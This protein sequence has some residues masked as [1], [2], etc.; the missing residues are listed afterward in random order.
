MMYAGKP[1]SIHL[2]ICDWQVAKVMWWYF[3][4]KAIELND[5]VLMVLRKKWNQITFLHVF[6]HA[7]M[8]NIWWWVMTFIPGG[9]CK[10]LLLF[11]FYCALVVL[12]WI[13]ARGT[14]RWPS[15]GKLRL[16]FF[17]FVLGYQ[18]KSVTSGSIVPTVKLGLYDAK[19]SLQCHTTIT[20][21][22]ARWFFQPR[23]HCS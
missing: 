12:S 6:H 9:L 3:F 11:T 19:E 1:N 10:L 8:L 16:I 17:K 23:C 2:W 5:T 21:S 4:S 13:V 7:T 20:H 22:P 15:P 18:C 14:Y